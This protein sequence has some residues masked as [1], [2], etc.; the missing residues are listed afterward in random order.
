MMLAGDANIGFVAGGGV[1]ERCLVAQVKGVAVVSSGLS[2]VEDGLITE[3]HA[4]D[5][6]EDLRGLACGEGKGDVE[7]QHQP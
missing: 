5:L 6:T 3:G 7:S 4:E 1:A 2:V